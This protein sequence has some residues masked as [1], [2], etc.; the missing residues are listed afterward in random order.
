VPQSFLCEAFGITGGL[1]PF[2]PRIAVAVERHAFNAK[3]FATAA[4]FGGTVICIGLANS[5]EQ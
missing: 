2:C 1:D 5:R 3:K 4:K